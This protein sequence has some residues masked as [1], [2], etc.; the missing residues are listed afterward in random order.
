[1]ISCCLTLTLQLSSLPDELALC[2][3]IRALYLSFNRMSAL[4]LVLTRIPTI[5]ELF[6]KA[7]LGG[8]VVAVS[9]FIPCHRPLTV[10][11]PSFAIVRLRTQGNQLTSLPAELA[12]MSGLEA[13]DAEMNQFASMPRS[14]SLLLRNGSLAA[15]RI[16]GNPFVSS[17]PASFAIDG[18]HDGAFSNATGSR[19]ASTEVPGQADEMLCGVTC[20]ATP[21]Q[22]LIALNAS[23]V[24]TIASTVFHRDA[25]SVLQ[26]AFHLPY[27]VSRNGTVAVYQRNQR[28][29]WTLRAPPGFVVA[30][31]FRS[32]V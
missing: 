10:L 16:A 9:A 12:T 4:P 20:R 6:I 31:R 11:R 23:S 2:T 27:N 8:V 18:K 3:N 7:S 19:C 28:C 21:A 26:F 22:G 32:D 1:M 25:K 14:L 30:V 17:P 15:L 13:L 24:G 29:D 5:S